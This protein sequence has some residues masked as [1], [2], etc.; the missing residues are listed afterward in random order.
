MGT[1]ILGGFA[2]IL[3]ISLLM[4]HLG[5]R[6]PRHREKTDPGSIGLLFETVSIPT[7]SDKRLFGWLI[8]SPGA[9]STLIMLHGWGGNAEQMLPL[10]PP[11]H[12]AGMHILLF[13]ARNHGRSDADT[14]SSLPRF[15]EDTEKAVEWLKRTHPR[16]TSKI[17]LLGH[18]VG[19]AA[20]LLAASRRKDIDAVISISAFAHPE[21]MM[22]RYLKRVHIPSLLIPP[23]LRYVEYVI[24]FRYEE[25]APLH[26]VCHIESPVLI[27]HGEED[28]TVPLEDALTIINRCNQPNI[29]LLRVEDAGH[30]SVEKI[31]IYAKELTTFLKKSR[32][33]LS[34]NASISRLSLS[35]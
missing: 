7:V 13:D 17:A 18:S 28:R 23:I 27:V 26:T 2:T 1:L 30:E 9:T 10:V 11:F 29:K 5:F 35:R 33:P 31:Q 20:V 32:F 25:I 21:W 16:Y 15:A 12:Q 4:I 8:P 24:G 19:G 34:Q 3:L 22:R 6:P 14:F